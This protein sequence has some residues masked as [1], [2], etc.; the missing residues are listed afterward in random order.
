MKALFDNQYELLHEIGHGAYG[1]VWL[2]R[3]FYKGKEVAIKIYSK[4]F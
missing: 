1:R 2:A 4:K 3:D